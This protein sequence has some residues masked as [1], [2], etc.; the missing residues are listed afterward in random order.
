MS[1][2]PELNDEPTTTGRIVRKIWNAQFTRHVHDV[3]FRFFFSKDEEQIK[4][5]IKFLDQFARD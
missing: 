5:C 2:P 4:A 1:N 3:R